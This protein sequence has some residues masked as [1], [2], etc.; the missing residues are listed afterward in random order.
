MNEF[1]TEVFI[2]L[3]PKV[4]HFPIAL[5]ITAFLFEILSL[6]SKKEALHKSALTIYMAATL[7]TPLVV[8]TGLWEEK[9]LHLHHPL[10]ERHELSGLLT[11]GISLISLP[12]I[13]FIKK[14]AALF[15]RTIFLMFLILIT[16]SV[17][18]TAHL[19][20]E[21]VYEYGIAVEK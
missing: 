8:A 3:H 13:W 18:I 17:T 21:M 10:L 19:G 4:V 20:G 6:V 2:P 14:R 11:M 12:I 1:L 16:L 15:F 5:F 7:L 9:R